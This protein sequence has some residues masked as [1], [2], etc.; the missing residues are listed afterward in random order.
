MKKHV[1]KPFKPTISEKSKM[2]GS[3]KRSALQKPIFEL[4][5]TDKS[6]R[7]K[8]LNHQ[9]NMDQ[10]AFLQN[11]KQSML[12]NVN[13]ASDQRLVYK[14]CEEYQDAFDSQLEQGE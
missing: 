8:R 10:K 7:E 4:L 12:K 11:A 14:F 13:D 5:H 1:D 6:D 2:L 9:Q 3:Q